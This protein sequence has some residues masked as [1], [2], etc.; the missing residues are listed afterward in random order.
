[1]KKLSTSRRNKILKELVSFRVPSDELE[2]Y[3]IEARRLNLTMTEFMLAALRE[4]YFPD[5]HEDEYWYGH[6]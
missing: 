6:A 5:G 1:M 4:K 2:F 3:R